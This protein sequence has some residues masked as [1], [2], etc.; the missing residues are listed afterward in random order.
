VCLIFCAMGLFSVKTACNGSTDKNCSASM[1]PSL[2]TASAFLLKI[3]FIAVLITIMV[4]LI[5]VCLIG[6]YVHYLLI[7][8]TQSVRDNCLNSSHHLILSHLLQ[9]DPRTLRLPL[10]CYAI[11]SILA[12]IGIAGIFFSS[13]ASSS[14]WFAVQSIYTYIII[15]SLTDEFQN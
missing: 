5:V 3:F 4:F 11:A 7:K 15:Y 10:I 6:F 9:R 14:V 1:T 2:T 8:G 13:I 12:L